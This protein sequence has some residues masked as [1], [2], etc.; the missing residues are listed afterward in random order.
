MAA[1]IS[2]NLLPLDSPGP[3]KYELCQNIP[4]KDSLTNSEGIRKVNLGWDCSK[5]ESEL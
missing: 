4:L 1:L 5:L 2:E 3:L